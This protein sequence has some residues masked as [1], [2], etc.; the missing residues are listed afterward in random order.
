M[1]IYIGKIEGIFGY[2]M[3][4][5]GLSEKECIEALQKEYSKWAK[6]HHYSCGFSKAFE[7]WGGQI[8]EV[9]KGKVYFDAFNE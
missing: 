2:G 9:K 5:I 6:H 8:K 4:V 3:S 7:H 1:K